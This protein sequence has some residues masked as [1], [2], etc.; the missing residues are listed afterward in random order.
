MADSVP[1]ASRQP[2]IPTRFKPQLKQWGFI[3]PQL[4][5]S[6]CHHLNWVNHQFRLNIWVSVRATHVRPCGPQGDVDRTAAAWQKD[7]EA[8]SSGHPDGCP[9]GF[10]FLEIPVFS[11]FLSL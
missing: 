9:Y 7:G 4:F 11:Y 3:G 2:G 1:V 6:D 10:G 5:T 8:L